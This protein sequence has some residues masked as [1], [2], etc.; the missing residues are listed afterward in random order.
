MESQYRPSSDASEVQSDMKII[1]D[2]LTL[3]DVIPGRILIEESEVKKAH[4]RTIT[5]GEVTGIGQHMLALSNEGDLSRP[6]SATSRQS[7]QDTLTAM[8]VTDDTHSITTKQSVPSV[9]EC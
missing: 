8:V 3:C 7:K 9:D 6:S 4:D 5:V 2:D 1:P